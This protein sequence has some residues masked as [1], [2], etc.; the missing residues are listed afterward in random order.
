MTKSTSMRPRALLNRVIAAWALAGLLPAGAHAAARFAGEKIAAVTPRAGANGVADLD[1]QEDLA[2]ARLRPY[3]SWQLDSLE[4][5]EVAALDR[6]SNEIGRPPPTGLPNAGTSPLAELDQARVDVL[7][8]DAD[9]ARAAAA[10]MPH[11]LRAPAGP[12]S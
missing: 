9:R 1:A 4:G 8:R 11:A 2:L 12:G 7:L 6:Q 3:R 5:A 10:A